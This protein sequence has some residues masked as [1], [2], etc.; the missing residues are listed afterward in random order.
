M[1]GIDLLFVVTALIV[2][3]AREMP[4]YHFQELRL[5]SFVSIVQL[6]VI[7]ALAY[8]VY[9][10]RLV[11]GEV[12]PEDF[13]SPRSRNLWLVICLGF[14]FLAVDEI[15]SIHVFLDRVSDA[16]GHGIGT[17]FLYAVGALGVLFLFRH[18]VVLFR[19]S[20][21]FFTAG[22]FCLL[23]AIAFDSKEIYRIEPWV[24][25]IGEIFLSYSGRGVTEESLE[26]VSECFFIGA[27]FASV[28]EA[29]RI[30]GRGTPGRTP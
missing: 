13:P 3:P 23:V 18:E 6:V 21:I 24:P 26:L 29:R 4:T 7:A 22:F 10:E 30:A 27:M 28:V 19:R 15:A 11:Q 25:K 9:L 5:I 17:I 16:L 20:W 12:T 14:L 1:L 8:Q 2:P